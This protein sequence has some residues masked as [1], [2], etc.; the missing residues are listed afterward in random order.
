M[1]LKNLIWFMPETGDPRHPS[2]FKPGKTACSQPT[3]DVQPSTTALP[4]L[5]DPQLKRPENING[6]GYNISQR[7]LI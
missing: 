2:S 7:V 4:H 5:L 6:S 3:C 1:V